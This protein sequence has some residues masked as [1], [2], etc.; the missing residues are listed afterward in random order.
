MVATKK[1]TARK[2]TGGISQKAQLIVPP[3]TLRSRSN[4]PRSP[5]VKPE[6][7]ETPG[8]DVSSILLD[9]LLG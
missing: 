8:D 6:P 7:A 9:L 2:T 4:S 1:N 3:R 5:S